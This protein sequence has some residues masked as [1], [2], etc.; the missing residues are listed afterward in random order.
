MPKPVK[1]I[2]PNLR[3]KMAENNDSVKDIADCIQKSVDS[4]R[5][6]LNG[7]KDFEL[8]EL[9]TLSKKYGTAIEILFKTDLNI[10]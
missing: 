5:S 2:F 7:S 10:N 6:R 9:Q 1:N 8:T 3:G 4:T